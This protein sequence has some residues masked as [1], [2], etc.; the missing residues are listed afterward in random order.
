M[1]TSPPTWTPRCPAVSWTDPPP[2]TPTAAARCW[3]PWPR[4]RNG[5]GMLGV[6]PG[7]R[8]VSLR[9]AAPNGIMQL[10]PFV[11]AL[12]YAA[13]AGIDVAL[14]GSSVRIP[15]DNCG[16]APAAVQTRRAAALLVQRAVDDARDRGVSVVAGSGDTASPL[17]AGQVRC[18]TLPQQTDRVV[19]VGATGPSGR[20]AAYADWGAPLMLAAPGGDITDYPDDP[21]HYFAPENMVLGAYPAALAAARGQLDPAGLPLDPTL[22]RSC[23]AQACA[24]YRWGQGTAVA[25]AH[26]AGAAALVITRYGS[27]DPVTGD[28]GMVP[29]DVTVRLRRTALQ[30][31]CSTPVVTYPDQPTVDPALC[32]ADGTHTTLTGD[33]LVDAAASVGLA[34]LAPP[35]AP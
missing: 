34:R 25:A 21:L 26:V 20:K 32:T 13:D 9:A 3:R 17:T 22:V 33:G 15:G 28:W 29:G 19:D 12:T 7:V 30:V 27:A 10:A 14:V 5:I 18:D 2:T 35:I 23:S 8:L 24:Y 1:P 11:E 6:A 31:P 4:H 16:D